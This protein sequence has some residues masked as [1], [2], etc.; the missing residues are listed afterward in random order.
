MEPQQAA[1]K[2][3]RQDRAPG[4]LDRLR[5]RGRDAQQAGARPAPGRVAVVT[6]SAAAV[7]AAWAAA[8]AATLAIVPMPVMIDGQMYTEGLDD[9][10]TELALA[11]ALGKP[12][13]TS[14]PA[15]GLVLRTYRRL[16]EA[17]FEEIVSLHLS[18]KLSGTVDAARWA[19]E[20]A[21][22]PVTVVDS[23]TV[24]LAQGFAVMDAVA[25]AEAGLSASAVAEAA[26]RAGDNTIG[27][28]VPS[29]EQLRKGGRIN[30][31]ASMFG[32][33]LAVK[34]L[35]AVADGQIVVREKVR[36]LPR[37][38]VRLV[39]LSRERAADLPGGARVA[40][41]YFGND[42]QARELVHEL[43]GSAAEPVLCEP[44]PAVLAAHTGAGVLAVVVAGLPG[45]ASGGPAPAVPGASDGQGS[46]TPAA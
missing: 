39:A 19:A 23:A 21:P 12:V 1:G 28:V 26:A 16:A 36:T 20:E 29:L 13:Q 17:G 11:L 33:L 42:E 9:V 38:L 27:F 46:A 3:A 32:T 4:W 45:P 18:A 22:V 31:A 7:P 24:G 41:Q 8:H 43:A 37:A 30:A 40:V 2:P 10:E 15:P 14:R 35:L 6:D 34:P 25:A 44:L 5:S